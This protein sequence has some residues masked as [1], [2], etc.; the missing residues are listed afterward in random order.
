MAI[1][2]VPISACFASPFV[3]LN[4]IPSVYEESWALAF[5]DVLEL[6]RDAQTTAEETRSLKWILILHDV[7]LRLPP[8]GGRRGHNIID[9]RFSVWAA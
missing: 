3:H 1:D 2:H 6:R 5:V 8:R 7:L 9:Q 4:D